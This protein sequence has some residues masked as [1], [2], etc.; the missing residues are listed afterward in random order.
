MDLELPLHDFM[1]HGNKLTRINVTLDFQSED[2]FT[3]TLKDKGFGEFFPAE[4]T[5][6]KRSF[7]VG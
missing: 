7:N 2:S 5:V 3:V 6:L 4:N 1:K